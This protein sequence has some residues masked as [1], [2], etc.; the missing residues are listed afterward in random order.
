MSGISIF[1]GGLNVS[2]SL[3]TSSFIDE[4]FFGE[5]SKFI[6]LSTVSNFYE[7]IVKAV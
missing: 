2:L 4:S 5:G 6:L 1:L 7:V 3:F